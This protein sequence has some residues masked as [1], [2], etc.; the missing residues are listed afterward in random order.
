MSLSLSLSLG[1][2]LIAVGVDFLAEV[3]GDQLKRLFFF[4]GV[5]H[6]F[7][8]HMNSWLAAEFIVYSTEFALPHSRN[9]RQAF[10]LRR[11]KIVVPTPCPAPSP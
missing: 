5:E 2:N 8:C 6:G 11:A 7:L 1:I 10:G 9:H 3:K 4:C